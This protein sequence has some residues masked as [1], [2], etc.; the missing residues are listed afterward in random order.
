MSPPPLRRGA[1]VTFGFTTAADAISWTIALLLGIKLAAT[2]IL[3]AGRGGPPARA[4]A[5]W[6]S[7]KVTPLFAVPLMILLATRAHD[8]AGLLV[9]PALL[10]FVLVAVPVKAW[11]RLR[12][13]SA[14]RP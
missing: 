14:A 13:A 5:L 3:L 7:T 1:K 2:V 6:W 10:A 9:Y 8:R 12:P 11:R 4:A